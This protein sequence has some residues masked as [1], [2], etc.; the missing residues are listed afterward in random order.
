MFASAT[1]KSTIIIIGGWEVN[2][3]VRRGSDNPDT[4]KRPEESLG[5]SLQ[6]EERREKGEEKFFFEDR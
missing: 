1:H 3:E 2:T 6:A 4:R 5:V